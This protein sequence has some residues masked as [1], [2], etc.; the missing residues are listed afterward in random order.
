MKTYF[1]IF[2]ATFCLLF[3]NNVSGQI[4]KKRFRKADVVSLSDS[5]T[6]YSQSDIFDFPNL[7]QVALYRD[8]QK[9]KNL[10]SL[11]TQGGVEFY[12][13]L[14]SYVKNFGIANFYTNTSMVWQLAKLSEQF[15]PPGESILLYK[16]V[17][18][19]HRQNVDVKKSVE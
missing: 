4:A 16:L 7:N 9:L 18:K 19:H 13:A 6:R 5:A 15:G 8:D 11:E 17:L 1:F 2:L 12:N 10:K 3:D 14:R